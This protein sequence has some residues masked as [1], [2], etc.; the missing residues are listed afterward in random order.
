MQPPVAP[1]K[2]SDLRREPR[3][4]TY[5]PLNNMEPAYVSM[6]HGKAVIDL[7]FY[8]ARIPEL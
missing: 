1:G 4:I 7:F 3:T 5:S 6:H 8:S 2:R